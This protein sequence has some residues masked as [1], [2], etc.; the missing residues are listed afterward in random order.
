MRSFC[1]PPSGSEIPIP[2]PVV[3]VSP[4]EEIILCW[5][6]MTMLTLRRTHPQHHFS[7]RPLTGLKSQKARRGLACSSLWVTSMYSWSPGWPAMGACVPWPRCTA[8][9][10]GAPHGGGPWTGRKCTQRPEVKVHYP[11]PL[12]AASPGSEEMDLLIKGR[13][14]GGGVIPQIQSLWLGRKDNGRPLCK[15]FLDS[16]LFQDSKHS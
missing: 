16:W 12:A 9:P 13:S 8:W 2:S 15:G 14:V 1:P 6:S 4:P 3:L 10:A 11:S 5:P 7:F